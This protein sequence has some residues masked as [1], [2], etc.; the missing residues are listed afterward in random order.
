MKRT[1]VAFSLA[2]L[3]LAANIGVAQERAGMSPLR[4]SAVQLAT[5]LPAPTV[6]DD[7]CLLLTYR[8]VMRTAPQRGERMAPDEFKALSREVCAE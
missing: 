2:V 4:F 1:L 6:S 8:L 3:G 7:E 5:G